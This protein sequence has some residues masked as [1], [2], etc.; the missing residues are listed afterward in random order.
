M[1][2]AAYE[3]SLRGYMYGWPTEYLNAMATSVGSLAMR[4]IA[5]MSRSRASCR[6]IESG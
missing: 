2:F 3:S 1:K 4:R 5:E 6:F